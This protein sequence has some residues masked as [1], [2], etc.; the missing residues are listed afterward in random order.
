MRTSRSAPREIRPR[1]GGVSKFFPASCRWLGKTKAEAEAKYEEL[2]NL[3][4]PEIGVRQLSSYFGFDLSK[5]SARRAGAGA[6]ETNA[7]QG[8]HQAHLRSCA[9][10]KSVDPQALSA[11]H[12]P[13]CASRPDQEQQRILP[14]RSRSGLPAVPATASTCCRRL[15]RAILRIFATR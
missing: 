1:A 7:E 9:T 2:Q 15:F 10:G 11:H 6:K 13:A 3:I 8:P 4:Q 5:V 14:T 12:R